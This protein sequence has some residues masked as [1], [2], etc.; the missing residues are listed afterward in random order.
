MDP[1]SQLLSQYPPD[2]SLI[3]C[4][5][6]GDLYL[7]MKLK[8]GRIGV[9]ATLGNTGGKEFD[10][11][12][13]IDLSSVY[14]RIRLIAYYNALFNAVAVTDAK[15]D[16]F[17]HLNFSQAGKIVMIGYFRPLVKK[18]DALSI[19]LSIFDL[20]HDDT[21]I[22]PYS[23]LDAVLPSAD[24][25]IVTSTTLVNNTFAKMISL[26]KQDAKAY[27]LGPTTIMHPVMFSYPQIRAIY[28]MSFTPGD[29]RPL[30]VVGNNGGTPDFSPFAQKIC[31]TRK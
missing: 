19:P 28:G 4:V 29:Q 2:P 30:E 5:I 8:D 11:S 24:T 18:F 7:A 9:C 3:D 14:S 16:I 1:L 23:I 31:M 22:T 12:I 20:A 25:V 21:R 27:M 13:N 6:Q 10:S 17:T 15:E 26:V